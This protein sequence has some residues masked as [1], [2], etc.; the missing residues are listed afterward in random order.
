M[1][2]GP[3]AKEHLAHCPLQQEKDQ[4]FGGEVS[5]RQDG[6]TQARRDIMYAAAVEL[7]QEA[8]SVNNAVTDGMSD[9]AAW[10]RYTDAAARGGNRLMYLLQLLGGEVSSRQDGGKGAGCGHEGLRDFDKIVGHRDWLS[11]IEDILDMTFRVSHAG[12]R[13]GKPS[14][15]GRGQVPETQG[16]VCGLRPGLLRRADARG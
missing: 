12:A 7:Q 1:L 8:R 15:A 3:I 10:V 16:Q 11:P 6:G 2:Q 13:R 9:E 14:E 5:S 4:G